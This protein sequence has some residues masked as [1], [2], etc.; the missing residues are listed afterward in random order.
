MI[1]QQDTTPYL[2]PFSH[3]TA[4]SRVAYAQSSIDY[5]SSATMSGC[6]THI[7]Y[8]SQNAP[9]ARADSASNRDRQW[10]DPQPQADGSGYNIVIHKC[11]G[12]SMGNLANRLA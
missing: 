10:H 4:G 12:N 6:N 9:A 8:Q 3:N 7:P 11:R 1:S 2:L 5:A